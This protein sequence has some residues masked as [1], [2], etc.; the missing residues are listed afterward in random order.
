MYQAL[1]GLPDVRSILAECWQQ[2]D[3][4]PTAILPRRGAQHPGC[5]GQCIKEGALHAPTTS[6]YA[7]GC[8]IVPSTY[9]MVAGFVEQ[10]ILTFSNDTRRPG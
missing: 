10:L 3:Y 1:S 5:H 4:L 8:R 2:I 6:T 9:V 7:V